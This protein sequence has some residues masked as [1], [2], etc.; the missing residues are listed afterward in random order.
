MASSSSA[1]TTKPTKAPETKEEPP[2]PTT[3][4]QMSDHID[5]ATFEQILEMD[6]EGEHDFSQGIVFGFFEQAETTFEKMETALKEKKLSELSSLGHFLKG[7]SATIGLTKVK[8]ACEK[9]QHYGAGKDES[10]TTDEPDEG[11]SLKKIGETI[12]TAKK[13][14]EEVEAF[15]RRYF[16]EEEAPSSPKAEKKDS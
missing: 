8:D 2:K 6:E 1:T 9:I 15:F 12:D 7:S 14:Y 4:A 11:V 13:D 5:Q 16:G 3:L 10:G